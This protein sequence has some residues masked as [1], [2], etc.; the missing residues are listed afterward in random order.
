MARKKLKML[1]SKEDIARMK[2]KNK[3]N[4]IIIDLHG[5]HCREAKRLINNIICI[6]TY[7]N[8]KVK[9]DLIHGYNHGTRLK[10]MINKEINHNKIEKVEAKNNPGKTYI[11]VG[12]I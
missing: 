8:T 3:K 10:D 9:L 5:M 7:E 6:Y 4:R 2:F 1:L 12:S 11:L